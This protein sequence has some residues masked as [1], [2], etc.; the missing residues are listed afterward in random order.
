MEIKNSR[1]VQPSPKTAVHETVANRKQK[2]E[3]KKEGVLSIGGIQ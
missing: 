3:L 1:Q 2:I